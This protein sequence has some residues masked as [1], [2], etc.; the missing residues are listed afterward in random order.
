ME[1]TVI[2]TGR[3]TGTLDGRIRCHIHCKV[4][5]PFNASKWNLTLREWLRPES[6]G[7]GHHRDYLSPDF[8]NADP[9]LRAR[10]D[11]VTRELA[12]IALKL[13][14]N[15][16]LEV[17]RSKRP[18]TH[19]VDGP[20]GAIPQSMPTHPTLNSHGTPFPSTVE[21]NSSQ[22]TTTSNSQVNMPSYIHPISDATTVS[23]SPGPP[24]QR[25]VAIITPPVSHPPALPMEPNEITP[26]VDLLRFVVQPSDLSINS[27]DHC[28]SGLR[29]ASGSRVP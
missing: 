1:N 25:A 22:L 7:G 9:E 19:A 10:I 26:F 5:S 12:A 23:P 2:N 29:L 15:A 28:I 24:I 18:R 11:R 4:C 21:L 20:P 6:V 3:R 13:A 17:N 27:P 14:Q 16:G 8:K